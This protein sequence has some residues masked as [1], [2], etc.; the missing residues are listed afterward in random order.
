MSEHFKI[1]RVNNGLNVSIV[2]NAG[3]EISG[4]AR[5]PDPE[6][7]KAVM[8]KAGYLSSISR[9]STVIAR[10]ASGGA[11]NWLKVNGDKFRGWINENKGDIALIRAALNDAI[12]AAEAEIAAIK[13]E[14]NAAQKVA[15]K[16][17]GGDP[18]I[19]AALAIL[20]RMTLE[21]LAEFASAARKNA[22]ID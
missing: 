15:E 1:V 10:P 2:F 7:A 8:I 4:S 5:Y 19:E 3:R 13:Q 6:N 16:R 21:Q 20:A 14:N 22:Y 9:D 18:Q 17:T 11:V 12:N